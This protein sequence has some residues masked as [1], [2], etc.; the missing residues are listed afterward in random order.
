M[1]SSGIKRLFAILL[2]TL[3]AITSGLEAFVAHAATDG[4]VRVLLTRVGTTLSSLAF[5]TNCVYAIGSPS[6]EK[7]PSGAS[8]KVLLANGKIS[9]LV[10]GV[11]RASDASLSLYRTTK[12]NVGATFTSPSLSN[13]YCGDLFF[14]VSSGAIR[15]VLRIYIEDYLYGVVAYEM[16]DSFPLE[17]LK[18]QAICARTYAMRLKKS[19][20]AYDVTDNTSNQVFKGYSSSWGNVISA[21]QATKGQCLTQNGAYVGCW[22]TASNGGQTESTKNIWGSNLSYSVVKDDPYD[23]ANPSS[24]EKSVVIPKKGALPPK[25]DTLLRTALSAP[26]AKAGMSG[27]TADIRIDEVIFLR[28]EQPKYPSPSR[29]YTKLRFGVRASS[30][31]PD[32]T[33]SS[34]KIAVDLLTYDQLR[35]ALSLDIPSTT[36]ETVWLEDTG[37]TFVLSMR[38]YG[39][40]VG[41]SQRGAQQMAK[42]HGMTAAQILSFYFPGTALESRAFADATGGTAAPAQQESSSGYQTLQYG[43][44]G[45]SVKRLQTRLRA[46]GYFGGS[47]GGNYL[48][49]TQSAVRAFQSDKGLP[50]DGIAS[51]KMQELLFT[52]DSA[53]ATPAPTPTS[54]PKK[55]EV[56][57][58]VPAGSVLRVYAKPKTT[59]KI[60]ATFAN[61]K[62]LR[63]HATSGDWAAVSSGTTKG[64]VLKKYLTVP[65]AP[66]VSPTV[67]PTAMPTSAPTMSPTSRP[68]TPPAA[69]GA[70]YGR[71]V[72]PANAALRVYRSASSSSAR[73]GALPNNAVVRIYGIKGNWAAITS[74]TIKG[75]IQKKYVQ[76]DA[77][78]STAQPS[79]TVAPS[80]SPTPIPAQPD[81]TLPAYARVS[82]PAP[83]KLGLRP[84][85]SNQ[86]QSTAYLSNATRIK[87]LLVNNDWA[88]ITTGAKTGYVPTKYIRYD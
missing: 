32:G 40:G 23:L 31:L 69:S 20:G 86:A 41:M 21:V 83:G 12:G 11:Q 38:R 85:P 47:I 48:A 6:G 54:A 74:G 70:L 34:A 71:I 28:L 25:L 66:T 37:D 52:E 26:V 58:H 30:L 51:P 76:P 18:A 22:Y 19:S 61:G 55:D 72:I 80:Q 44:T 82:L 43:D 87:V 62:V 16:S 4:M 75:Y 53:T 15:P 59:A 49:Q 68:T 42:A 63:L 14:T 35:S 77:P 60:V 9:L 3:L 13:V 73:V 36:T 46:L 88:R 8:V 5:R 45:E 50:V 56:R 79:A 1:K 33:R 64:Y 7:I 24:T 81:R 29:T 84:S 78:A 67:K 17:A 10:D 65:A 2:V 39:H 27:A 57:V